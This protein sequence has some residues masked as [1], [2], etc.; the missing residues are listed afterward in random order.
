MGKLSLIRIVFVMAFLAALFVFG[1]FVTQPDV[2]FLQFV[3]EP[4]SFA[5]FVYI[6]AVDFFM[7]CLRQVN[8]FLGKDNLTKLIRGDF[9]TPREEE[10]IFMFLDLQGSTTHA[11]NLG[12]ITYSKLIQ[13]CFNE[14]G[15]VIENEADI[16]Q[17]VGDEAILTWKLREGLRNQNCIQ[18]YYNFKSKLQKK[19]KYYMDTYGC[20]PHFK[21]GLNSGIVTV[22]EIGKYKKEI[23]YHG[24]TINVAARIQAKCNVLNRELLVSE[25]LV[26]QL[27]DTPI[28]FE[29]MESIEL[30][31]K[32]QKV[33]IHA[34]HLEPHLGN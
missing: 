31:G 21:A 20:M 1:Y 2:S 32:E 29:K 8:L 15:V 14:L 23:A 24:D 19:E 17:Y 11:E 25:N 4:G 33:L 9:Y 27:K 30:K 26:N 34:A 5:M 22:T 18:A 7:L 28:N 13:D 10:R 6:V 12:H 16:Y 3:F